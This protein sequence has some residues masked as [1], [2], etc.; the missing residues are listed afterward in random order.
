MRSP[1]TSRD[2]DKEKVVAFLL[3][4]HFGLH[5][6]LLPSFCSLELSLQYLCLT[7][8]LIPS[9]PLRKVTLWMVPSFIFY[10]LSVSISI[11]CFQG[12]KNLPLSFFLL[13]PIFFKRRCTFFVTTSFSLTRSR[14]SPCFIGS[15]SPKLTIHLYVVIVFIFWSS[16]PEYLESL[17]STCV[18]LN[19]HSTDVLCPSL[20]LSGSLNS[21][22]LLSD[23]LCNHIL[24]F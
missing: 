2:P 7:S 6:W 9:H 17:G 11:G 18:K 24:L 16:L 22:W 21:F 19:T 4:T 12:F 13:H 1:L 5:P 8:H 14:Q 23:G 15:A 3:L 20:L 10:I